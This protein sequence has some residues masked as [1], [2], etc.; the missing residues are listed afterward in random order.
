MFQLS[1]EPS[2]Q[3]QD[4][5]LKYM[6]IINRDNFLRINIKEP[7]ECVEFSYINSV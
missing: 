2:F 4:F 3:K 5:K 1:P 6:I 7:S